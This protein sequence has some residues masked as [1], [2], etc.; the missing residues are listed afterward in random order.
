MAIYKVTDAK[1]GQTST[2]DN[3]N[4][5]F[6]KNK[7]EGDTY[8]A[9]AKELLASTR[10]QA[11]MGVSIETVPT[12][13]AIELTREELSEVSAQAKSAKAR[14]RVFVMAAL[15]EITDDDPKLKEHVTSILTASK[16]APTNVIKWFESQDKDEHFAL[17]TPVRDELE[18][19]AKKRKD[20]RENRQA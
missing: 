18:R 16:S 19:E 7:L 13:Q 20:K 1:T 3:L 2:V 11:Q 4:D 12:Q 5:L 8:D 15:D 10:L 14:L 9:F 6:E 17:S